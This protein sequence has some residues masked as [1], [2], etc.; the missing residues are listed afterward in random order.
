MNAFSGR[1]NAVLYAQDST[2]HQLFFELILRLHEHHIPCEHL[3]DLFWVRVCIGHSLSIVLCFKA[4][5]KNR[6]KCYDAN[7]VMEHFWTH[8]WQLLRPIHRKLFHLASLMVLVELMKLTG[9]YILKLIIDI[10]TTQG[11]ENIGYISLLVISMFIAN[12]TTSFV[13]YF[14]ARLNIYVSSVAQNDLYKRSQEKLVSLDLQYHEKENTGNKVGKIHRGVDKISNLLDNLFW[15]VIPTIFQIIITTITLLWINLRF[16][17]IFLIF[18]PIFIILTYR[19]NKAINPHR[20]GI[21]DGFEQSQGKMTQSVININ[22]V[23]SFSQEKREIREYTLIVDTLRD[24]ILDMFDMIFKRNIG[25]DIAVNAAEAVIIGFSI[26]LVY[27]HA[28]TIG[29]FVFIITISQKALISMWRVT[30]LYDKILESSEALNRLW[31]ILNVE[32]VIKNPKNPFYPKTLAHDIVLEHVTFS[33]NDDELYALHNIHTIIPGGKIT[34]LVGPSGGGKTT[35]ARMIYRHYDPQMGSI[36][37]DEHDLKELDVTALRSKIAIVPQEVELF[38]ASI[39]DNIAY[40]KPEA[41]QEEIERAAH[42]ANVDEFVQQLTDRYETLVGERGVKLSGGQRQRVGIARAILAN[43]DILIF[44]EATSNL[45]SQSEHLIQDALEHITKDRTTIII[46]HRL[47]TIQKADK[48]IVLENGKVVEDGT[49]KELANKKGGLYA[50]LLQL[51]R[52]G[53]IM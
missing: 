42:I 18:I 17:I 10:I 52:V 48:I 31:A 25:R 37:I 1:I 53:D 45:D 43:P 23:K 28:V 14:V 50:H 12:Q 41:T 2:A 7:I 13:M 15:D 16:G 33:Y 21:S 29:S 6:E 26:Y 35:L 30:R 11:I 22:T 8:L 3:L 32:S 5:F 9:P 36:S 20:K 4:F 46:A 19:L 47:S 44:D 24:T 51:Q 34:A 39:R 49:H 40:A 27:T 38:N